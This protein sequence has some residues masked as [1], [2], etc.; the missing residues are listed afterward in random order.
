MPSVSWPAPLLLVALLLSLSLSGCARDGSGDDDDDDGPPPVDMVEYYFGD[1]TATGVSDDWV[2][3]SSYLV[4]RSL[5]PGESR[6]SEELYNT[7]DGTAYLVELDVDVAASTFTLAFADG[8]Y[9][10]SGTL[11]GPSWAWTSWESLSTAEDGSSVA[12]TDTLMQD[13][14]LGPRLVVSKL[15]Y[16]TAGDLEWTAGEVFTAIDESEWNDRFGSLP[17]PSSR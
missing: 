3:T 6:I 9:T 15:G 2:S 12:S 5:F 13:P 14:E 1:S 8:S 10:G 17:E 7:G 4:R 16:T 11:T